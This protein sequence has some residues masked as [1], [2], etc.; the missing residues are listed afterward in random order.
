MDTRC[1]VAVK[2]AIGMTLFGDTTVLSR[3][4][5]ECKYTPQVDA[6]HHDKETFRGFPQKYRRRSCS[7]VLHSMNAFGLAHSLLGGSPHLMLSKQ[8][9]YTSMKD[10]K[11]QGLFSQKIPMLLNALNLMWN[12]LGALVQKIEAKLMDPNVSGQISSRKTP[13]LL[14]IEESPYS[15]L[16]GTHASRRE[17]HAASTPRYLNPAPSANLVLHDTKSCCPSHH[18]TAIC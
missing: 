16:S 17:W 13:S 12:A 18:P 14:R 11:Y 6:G 7:V 2:R 15:L 9:I 1:G 4:F 10:S 5:L 3:F 8:Q